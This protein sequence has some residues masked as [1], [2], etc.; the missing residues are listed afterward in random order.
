MKEALAALGVAPERIHVEI[1]NGSESMTPGV[2]GAAT[3]A[4][5]LPKDDADTGPLVSFARSGIAAHWKASATRASW[6]WPRRA[7]SRSAGRAGPVSVTTARAGW[8]RGRSPTD[9]SRSTSPPTATCSCAARSRRATSSSTCD[10]RRLGE[11]SGRKWRTGAAHIRPKAKRGATSATSMAVVKLA[12]TT[13][14]RRRAIRRVRAVFYLVGD[15]ARVNNSRSK[16]L[17]AMSTQA[18]SAAYSRDRRRREPRARDP[19]SR[20]RQQ[21]HEKRWT[22][23]IQIKRSVGAPTKRM[24]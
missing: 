5:H 4:P 18:N 8:S 9:R 11:A 14:D 10:P 15:S 22:K 19:C 17:Y 21:R 13:R 2:V 6:S 24:R 20:E 23:S 16:T 1:F 7:T 12:S 3:R